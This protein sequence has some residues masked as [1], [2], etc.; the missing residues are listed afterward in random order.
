MATLC[1][2]TDDYN[3]YKFKMINLPNKYT[4]VDH[5]Q[6]K[7]LDHIDSE[8]YNEII[9][10][11]NKDIHMFYRINW[12]IYYN[13]LIYIIYQ[14]IICLYGAYMY[15][16]K[17][18]RDYVYIIFAMVLLLSNILLSDIC[19]I[20]ISM[21]IKPVIYNINRNIRKYSEKNKVGWK[22][23]ILLKDTI[24]QVYLKYYIYRQEYDPPDPLEPN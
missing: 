20:K 24:D 1:K 6:P 10:I 4:K 13:A 22:F 21:R 14:V 2:S 8:K 3:L 9:N 15:F 5:E 16:V 19:S 11:I 17:Q 7:A 12:D 18:E 23:E